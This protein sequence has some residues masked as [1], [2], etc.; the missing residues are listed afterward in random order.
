MVDLEAAGALLLV[1]SGELADVRALLDELGLGFREEAPTAAAVAAYA[2][3]QLVVAPPQF[4][5]D[6][7]E[8][9]ADR[10]PVRVAVLEGE[11]RTLRGMLGRSGIEWIVRR[12]FH[13]A[14]LRL[15]LLHCIYQGPEKRRAH[16]VGI[17]AAVRLQVGWRRRGALLADLSE[18]DCRLLCDR[19]VEL[20]RRVRLRL[21]ADLVGRPSLVIDAE[22]A[23]TARGSEERDGHEVCLVFRSLDAAAELRLK[24]L[25]ARHERGPAVLAGREARL[26]RVERP[27][28]PSEGRRARR[29][30]ISFESNEEDAEH[31]TDDHAGPERRGLP[32]HDFRRRVIALGEEAT[33]V[34]VGRD[35]SLRGMRVDPNDALELGRSLQI[36]IHVPSCETP[37][38]VDVRVHRK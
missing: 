23:R 35:I 2:E 17:G 15:L 38:V 3:A 10:V 13:P 28:D 9:G 25:V 8:E 37:L 6:R 12:P 34:L 21:P 1:H 18:R 20:G 14:A 22:V 30:V 32:R 11:A 7:L 26:Q 16:R 5:L 31:E 27:Q 33:R 29:S 4:L 19:P 24:E 36:A